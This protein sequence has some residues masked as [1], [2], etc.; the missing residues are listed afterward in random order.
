MHEYAVLRWVMQRWIAC[1]RIASAALVS[2]GKG[3]VFYDFKPD[4]LAV[5]AV[6]TGS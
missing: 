2:S 1:A 4:Y 5:R 3:F 6:R